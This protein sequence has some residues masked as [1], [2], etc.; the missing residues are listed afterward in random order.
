M[1]ALR[2]TD[3]AA[4]L[5]RRPTCD[6]AVETWV[7]VVHT[8]FSSPSMLRASGRP[9]RTAISVP[10]LTG[11]STLGTTESCWPGSMPSAARDVADRAGEGAD[12]AALAVDREGHGAAHGGVRRGGADEGEDDREGQSDEKGLALAEVFEACAHSSPVFAFPGPRA[13][14]SPRAIAP[15]LVLADPLGRMPSAAA[16]VPLPA[17]SRRP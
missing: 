3:R 15:T 1:V 2:L 14:S 16:A 6:R 8:V 17:I 12:L 7:A 10:S 4:P 11:V 9:T 5:M 13:A